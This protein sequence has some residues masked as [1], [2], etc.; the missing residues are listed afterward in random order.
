MCYE[1]AEAVY[2]ACEN[3]YKNDDLNIN[4]NPEGRILTSHIYKAIAEANLW[5]Y[6]HYN[7]SGMPNDS[8]IL[9][10]EN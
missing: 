2:D 1:L 6:H 9:Y 10:L 7:N 8:Y 3:N 5:T 4:R